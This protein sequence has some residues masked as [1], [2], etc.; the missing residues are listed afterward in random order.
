M[1]HD[2][3]TALLLDLR[4]RFK[5]VGMCLVLWF[6]MGLLWLGLL[7]SQS[8]GRIGPVHPLT[9]QDLDLAR[10][11]GLGE[12]CQVVEDLHLRLSDFI[13]RVAVHRREEA[14]REWRKWLRE[15]PL[16]HPHSW[17]RLD[18]VPPAPFLR[19]DHYHS[20][21]FWGSR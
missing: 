7:S 1:Y 9:V 3:S 2:A 13:H 10:R 20:W 11:G 8:S 15:D 16:I 12:W 21:R 5:A 6:G 17:L 18:L 14:F 19:C 4:R